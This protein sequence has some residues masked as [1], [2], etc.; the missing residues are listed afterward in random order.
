MW[1]KYKYKIYWVGLV[2]LHLQVFNAFLSLF[3]LLCL[4]KK[5]T[6]YLLQYLSSFFFLSS[7]LY[8]TSSTT[9]FNISFHS[10]GS[11]SHNM[12][13]WCFSRHCLTAY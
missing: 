1:S 10:T 7:Q 13:E 12:V 3:C 8:T 5:K 9:Q 2:T 11:I 6:A 4:E